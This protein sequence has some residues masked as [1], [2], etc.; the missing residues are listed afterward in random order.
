MKPKLGLE[1]SLD[2]GMATTEA[3][4]SVTPRGVG[5]VEGQS[6]EEAVKLGRRNEMG[7]LGSGIENVEQVE[8]GKSS[9]VEVGNARA[10]AHETVGRGHELEAMGMK[11]EGKGG[12]GGI[13][14]ANWGVRG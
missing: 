12:I 13:G 10:A 5:R 9:T 4:Q 8:A 14:N 3:D 11:S 2:N 7:L 1:I 6:D